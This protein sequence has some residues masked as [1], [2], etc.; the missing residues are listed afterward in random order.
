M[1]TQIIVFLLLISC[2]S[3]ANNDLQ[4]I[5]LVKRAISSEAQLFI[6]TD[7][8]QYRLEEMRYD[9]DYKIVKANLVDSS[10]K[11]DEENVLHLKVFGVSETAENQLQIRIQDI[12]HIRF[13]QEKY[14]KKACSDRLIMSNG[15][16]ICV[17]VTAFDDTRVQYKKCNN[18][19][20]RIFSKELRN[21]DKILMGET[22]EIIVQHSHLPPKRDKRFVRGAL[23]TSLIFSGIF[24]SILAAT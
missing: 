18:K 5:E 22:N 16:S 24:I 14:I 1:R 12:L 8:K 6:K 23:V 17:T 4:I 7:S 10:A 21:V 20:P 19:D 2:T 13:I 9:S 11:V 3:F 15:D